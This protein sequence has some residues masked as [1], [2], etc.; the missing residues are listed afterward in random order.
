MHSRV[1][2]CFVCLQCCV[3]T[4]SSL[5]KRR[6]LI[7]V[8]VRISLFRKYCIMRRK[9]RSIEESYVRIQMAYPDDPA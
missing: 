3:T 5:E 7:L 4:K 8:L 9:S 1:C 6:Q 2:R